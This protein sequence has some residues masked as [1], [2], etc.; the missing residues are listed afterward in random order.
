MLGQRLW[1][2]VAFVVASVVGAVVHVASIALP[3][4]EVLIAL[5]VLLAGLWL[6]LASQPSTMTAVPFVLAAA[7]LLHGH[8][9]AESIIGA[10]R[11]VLGAYALGFC[12]VQLAVA[13]GVMLVARWVWSTGFAAHPARRVAGAGIASVGAV[14]LAMALTPGL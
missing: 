3:F 11:H 12:I 2:P 1:L 6:L 7:G 13:A 8:A 10:D 5:S 4:A 9:Y 14:A